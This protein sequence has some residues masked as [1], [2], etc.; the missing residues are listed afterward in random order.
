MGRKPKVKKPGNSALGCKR[1]AQQIALAFGVDIDKDVVRR[2]LD[3]ALFWTAAD[4][5]EKLRAFQCYFNRH[6]AHSGLEGGLPEH[7]RL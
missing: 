2:Y 7:R 4:L 6:R 3:Q 1:I 5:E